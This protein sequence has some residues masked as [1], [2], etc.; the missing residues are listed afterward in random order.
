MANIPKG[1]RKML[2]EQWVDQWSIDL[3]RFAYRLCGKRE[4]AEDLVQET[5]FHA[6]RSFDSLR[7]ASRARAWLFQIL[8]FRYSHWVRAD[9]RRPKLTAPLDAAGDPS[10]SDGGQMLER[11]A[12]SESLQQALDGLDERYRVPLL[13]VF[14]E[15][16]TCKETAEKLDVPL[17]TVLSRIHRARQTLKKTL[18]ET[19][20]DSHATPQQPR[21]RL[22]G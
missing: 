9:T 2:Y 21:L 10:G 1:E 6:W 13:M 20:G 15:G 12:L 19:D 11:M 4:I 22:G 7:E 18:S 14:M 16:L 3:F 5:F 8:R 17:G